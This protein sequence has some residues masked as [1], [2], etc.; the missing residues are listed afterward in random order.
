MNGSA[1]HSS[2]LQAKVDLMESSTELFE[3]NLT[4]AKD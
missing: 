1:S 4:E 3:L 2:T